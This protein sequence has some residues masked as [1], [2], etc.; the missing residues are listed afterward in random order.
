M[1]TYSVIADGIA[2]GTVCLRIEPDIRSLR[3]DRSIVGNHSSKPA[4]PSHGYVGHEDGILDFAVTVDA[5][6]RGKGCF[7]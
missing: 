3:N 6:A 2:P 5:H 7:E 4:I 1:T